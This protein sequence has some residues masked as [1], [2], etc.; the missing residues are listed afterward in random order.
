[1]FILGLIYILLS[2]NLNRC[3]Q[4]YTNSDRA[5]AGNVQIIHDVNMMN[6]EADGYMDYTISFKRQYTQIPQVFI[7]VSAL[8]YLTQ[9]N[10]ISYFFT[11]QEVDIDK[12][13]IRIYKFGDTKIYANFFYYQIIQ[14]KSIAIT[15]AKFKIDQGLQQIVKFQLLIDQ[16]KL[17]N[18]KCTLLGFNSTNSNNL[19][20]EIGIQTT[21]YDID[22]YAIN[23]ITSETKNMQ[24]LLVNCIEFYTNS[25]DSQNDQYST[26]AN[27]D[28]QDFKN[29]NSNKINWIKHISKYFQN[30]Q[31]EIFL[32]IVDMENNHK[33]T[34][35]V[36]LYINQL[37]YS[38]YQQNMQVYADLD[39]LTTKLSLLLFSYQ[40]YNCK[41]SESVNIINHSDEKLCV[42]QCPE[43]YYM[44]IFQDTNA[45]R[46][47]TYN[48]LVC[49]DDNN[50]QICQSGYILNSQKQCESCQSQTKYYFNY[51]CFEKQPDLSYC[52]SNNI[53]QKCLN[54]KCL[55]CDSSLQKCLRCT[56]S[57]YQYQGQCYVQK[58]QNAYC[59][60]KGF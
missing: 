30:S 57:L 24:D 1:M 29:I 38:N 34:I 4:I 7:G 35:A 58:P 60:Q 14:D 21:I 10:N 47:C 51:Q 36:R 31:P 27:L 18:V 15:T 3:K 54:Q 9:T 17:R 22:H 16:K 8:D 56:Q 40:M 12:A 45:C 39:S 46:K 19:L 43:K 32:G 49:N 5:E 33:D 50:C 25:Q 42:S 28:E 26:I 52:D 13:I 53:C 44:A 11:V 59:I 48:C 23:I 20:R 2:I 37:D 55:Y 41:A 6:Q